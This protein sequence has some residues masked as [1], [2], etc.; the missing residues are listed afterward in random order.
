MLDG[1]HRAAERAVRRLHLG[2][3]RDGRTALGAAQH[4][5]AN[6]PVGVL[7][8]RQRERAHRTAQIAVLERRR[9]TRAVG[10]RLP[11]Q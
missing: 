4:L 6:R 3:E 11:H 10:H 5:G 8:W 9:A 2:R 1:H 7:R